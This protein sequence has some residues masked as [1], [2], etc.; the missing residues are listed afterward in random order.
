[1]CGVVAVPVAWQVVWS[2]QQCSSRAQH[3]RCR[4]VGRV[5]KQGAEKPKICTEIRKPKGGWV[6]RFVSVCELNRCY[7]AIIPTVSASQPLFCCP[8]AVKDI[9]SCSSSPLAFRLVSRQYL[10]TSAQGMSQLAR[11]NRLISD[12]SE[13]RSCES[14]VDIWFDIVIFFS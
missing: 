13:S 9:V 4:Y 11:R 10:A 1:M 5:W 6:L 2:S 14:S 8:L 3:Y 7:A 12:P